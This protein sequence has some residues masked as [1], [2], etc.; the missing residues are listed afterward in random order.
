LSTV[1]P[2]RIVPDEGRK[3]PDSIVEKIAPAADAPA[4]APQA[5]PDEPKAEPETPKV[6][7]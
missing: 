5:A 2:S 6:P 1:P 7:E 3:A 4:V